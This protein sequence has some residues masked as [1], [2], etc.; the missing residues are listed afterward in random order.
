MKNKV[1]FSYAS[2]DKQFAESAKR[3]LEVRGYFPEDVVFVDAQDIPMGGNIRD[4][5]KSEMEESATVVLVVSKSAT[6]SEWM[7]YEAGLAD[8]LGKNIL[9]V[10]EEG[11]ENDQLLASL[12]DYQ[13]VDL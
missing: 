1:F 7:N 9:V 6:S 12:A 8:A 3:E 4:H 13:R 11:A 5:L 10:G 2:Q